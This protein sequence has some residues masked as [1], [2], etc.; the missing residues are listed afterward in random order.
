MVAQLPEPDYYTLA[1]IAEKWDVSESYLLRLGSEGKLEFAWRIPG[2]VYVS[3]TGEVDHPETVEE[4]ERLFPSLP[5][6]QLSLRVICKAW[7][8]LEGFESLARESAALAVRELWKKRRRLGIEISVSGLAFLSRRSLGDYDEQSRSLD[9]SEFT[10]VSHF[11]GSEN[12]P[13]EPP[14]NRSPWRYEIRES[15]TRR[16]G[17]LP[18]LP[19]GYYFEGISL[20]HTADLVI[21]TPEI[22]RIEGRHR[23]AE[24]AAAADV[25]ST[26]PKETMQA[27]IAALAEALADNGGP[28]LRNGKNVNAKAVAEKIAPMIPDRQPETI[29]KA[30]SEAVGAGLTQR[31]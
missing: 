29:R 12:T 30:I 15:T 8:G 20:I 3:I 17:P 10:R 23:E 4:V 16:G 18:P 6:G 22:Q 19:D 2:N 9:S 26:K 25:L 11:T 24:N 28:R 27:I 5:S 13:N 21:S 7:E 31:C 1:E 14:D